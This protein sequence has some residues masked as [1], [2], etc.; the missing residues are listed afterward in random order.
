MSRSDM[1]PNQVN[2][3]YKKNYKKTF[4]TPNVEWIKLYYFSPYNSPKRAYFQ[5]LPHQA[6]K[7]H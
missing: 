4:F 3:I 1:Y 5:T 7:I 6:K 2:I